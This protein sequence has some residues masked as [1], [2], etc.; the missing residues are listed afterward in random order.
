MSLKERIV[1]V[2]GQYSNVCS[3]PGAFAKYIA[4]KYGTDGSINFLTEDIG[5]SGANIYKIK[6]P[7][8]SLFNSKIF[9]GFFYYRQVINFCKKNNISTVIYNT[10][11]VIP[12]YH[13]LFKLKGL[14]IYI[15]INDANFIFYY[16][17]IRSIVLYRTLE[18]Y[19]TRHSDLVITN[20]HYLTNLVAEQYGVNTGKIKTLY[21]GVDMQL[22]NYVQR[23]EIID[24]RINILF[25]KTEFKRGGLFDL[26]KALK[27]FKKDVALNIAGPHDERERY[28]INYA[29]KIG[30]DKPLNFY[31]RV[32]RDKLPAIYAANDI[33]C[34]PSRSEALGVVFLEAMSTGMAVIG[35][36]V[37][38][39]P[40][41]LDNGKAGWMAKAGDLNDLRKTI[42][43]VITNH[44]ERRAKIEHGRSFVKNFSLDN[45]Y[46]SFEKVV[47]G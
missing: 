26:M 25:V 38:G 37:G 31:G 44:R 23:R 20:S 33:L 8:F 39:I 3:G 43:E 28:I 7:P 45:L 47:N 6:L 12:F 42:W 36:N 10:S 9:K 21:K 5:E 1:F 18:R 17:G 16:R 11:S 15:M 14:K 4:G 35:T 13:F 30:F 27:G 2:T 40:E 41:V 34:V 24:G 29:N 32:D 19:V 22:F 46:T